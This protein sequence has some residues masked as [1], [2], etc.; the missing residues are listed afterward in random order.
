MGA[1]QVDWPPPAFPLDLTLQGRRSVHSTARGPSGTNRSSSD[2]LSPNDSIFNPDDWYERAH[3]S[4]S[5]VERDSISV[6]RPYSRSESAVSENERREEQRDANEFVNREQD[7]RQTISR[8]AQVCRRKIADAKSRLNDENN[9]FRRESVKEEIEKQENLL[10]HLDLIEQ[11]IGTEVG[12]TEEEENDISERLLRERQ[13]PQ[14]RQEEELKKLE[15]ELKELFD[16]LQ[17]PSL[18]TERQDEIRKNILKVLEK[19]DAIRPPQVRPANRQQQGQPHQQP[20]SW[21]GGAAHPSR[22]SHAPSGGGPG[23]GGGR[24]GRSP[25]GGGANSGG[26]VKS[27]NQRIRHE[28][29]AIQKE[30]EEDRKLLKEA[31]KTYRE[32]FLGACRDSDA[33]DGLRHGALGA[34]ESFS[35]RNRT[36]LKRLDKLVGQS[37]GFKS[38]HSVDPKFLVSI[39]TCKQNCDQFAKRLESI[40]EMLQ[41]LTPAKAKSIEL[42]QRRPK[43][44]Q[45]GQAIRV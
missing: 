5:V 22:G 25:A 27:D 19:Q 40:K 23:A 9:P 7:L 37:S 28:L 35:G 2:S 45:R 10:K 44:L 15:T 38:G 12:E 11:K 21:A 16:Q 33:F 39:T 41:E 13:D 43:I 34:L 30:L 32:S 24:K 18:S 1:R 42:S 31:Y 17:D 8:A 20:Q 36:R 29:E 14:R 3:S 4:D 6:E 26:L